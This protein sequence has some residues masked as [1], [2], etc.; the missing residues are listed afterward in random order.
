[1]LV[2]TVIA[3]HL[4]RETIAVASRAPGG[5]S[6]GAPDGCCCRPDDELGLDNVRGALGGVPADEGALL[7]GVAG[8]SVAMLN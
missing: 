2:S 4:L 6:E 1:M 8:A 5:S 3:P 7:R